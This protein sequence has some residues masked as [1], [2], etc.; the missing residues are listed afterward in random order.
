M[1]KLII[2]TIT[3]LSL[4]VGTPAY[5]VVDQ[6]HDGSSTVAPTDMPASQ[7][8]SSEGGSSS[9]GSD[10]A[11]NEGCEGGVKTSI[12]GG[13]CVQDDGSGDS[14]FSIL[15]VVL[16]ILTFGVGIAATLGIVISGIQYLTAKDDPNKVATAKMR[17][18]Q[19]VIG[20]FLYAIMWGLL[21]FLLPGGLFSNGS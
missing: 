1:K 3:V 19:I 20:L 7:Q 10:S 12:L 8:Q 16:T 11:F 13:G 17:M 18:L 5:A 9:G 14:V 2:S 4:L 15:N 21:N 6:S